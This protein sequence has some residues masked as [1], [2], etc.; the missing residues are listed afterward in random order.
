MR[1][2]ERPEDRRMGQSMPWTSRQTHE[3]CCDR[4]EGRGGEEEED[5]VS[6]GT[7]TKESGM[8][9]VKRM[10]WRPEDTVE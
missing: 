4:G 2:R 9:V 7:Q 8:I 5:N 6:E 1:G 3:L 10:K